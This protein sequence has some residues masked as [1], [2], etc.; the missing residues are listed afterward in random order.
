MYFENGIYNIRSAMTVAP[1]QSPCP[2]LKP[3]DANTER[4]LVGRD[5]L[6]PPTFSV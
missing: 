4:E 1:A 2:T 6:E 5:G 3:Q